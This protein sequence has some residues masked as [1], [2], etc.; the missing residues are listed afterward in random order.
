MRRI[1]SAYFARNTHFGANE[2]KKEVVI[3][4]LTDE[5]YVVKWLSQYGALPRAQIIKM[6]Q[7]PPQTA[8]KILRNLKRQMRI[9][10]VSGGYYIGLDPMCQP[11]QRMILAIWVL[12]RFIDKVEPMAHYPA[13]YPSQI[14]FL[15]E[16]IGYEI[17]VLYDG[18]QH[19]ARLLQPQEDLRY[20]FVLP[21]IR[22]AQELVLPNV[23]CLFATV[24]YNG[25]EVPNVRFYTESEGGG[26]GTV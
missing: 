11:D 12:L 9:A 10:D 6:L 21:H 16:D 26:N 17:V 8:E 15:K 3:V 2:Y 25:Q 7:K 13:T 20:I 18:E 1:N 4:L 19:L 24:D 23:P 14:F 5:Q 22:M